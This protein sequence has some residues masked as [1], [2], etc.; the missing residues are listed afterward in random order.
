MAKST[1]LDISRRVELSLKAMVM[2]RE[3]YGWQEIADRL[4][5]SVIESQELARIAY[6]QM[7]ID[8]AENIRVEVE[9]RLDSIVRKATLDLSLAQSQGERT[10]LYRV[11]LAAEAQR[12]RLLGIELPKGAPDA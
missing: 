5:V 2:K 6:G 9:D 1:D 8:T 12:A 7:A 4:N 10:A 11:L 3:G